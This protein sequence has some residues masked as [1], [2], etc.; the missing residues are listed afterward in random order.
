[1]ASPYSWRLSAAAV[2][3]VGLLP[4]HAADAPA[5]DLWQVTT[6]MSMEG[7]P[8]EM[9]AQTNQV[10]A[11]RNWTR[12]PTNPND[13]MKCTNTNF[14]ISGQKA[15]WEV[16]CKGPPAMTGTGEITRQ[17]ADAYSGTIKISG[18]EGGMTIQISGHKVGVCDNPS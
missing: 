18:E 16:S 8:M 3:V 13:P 2:I 1:M 5:G 17:G 10:C 14:Q 12:P 7:M 4:V 15:T 11:A 6:K 9:P